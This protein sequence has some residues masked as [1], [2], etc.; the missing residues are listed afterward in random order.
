MDNYQNGQYSKLIQTV[1][2]AG[3]DKQKRLATDP[4]DKLMGNAIKAKYA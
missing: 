2:R 4:Q 1:E 3:K